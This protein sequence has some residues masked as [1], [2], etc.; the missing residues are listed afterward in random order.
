MEQ[1]IES[2]KLKMQEIEKLRVASF[3]RLREMAEELGRVGI[4]REEKQKVHAAHDELSKDPLFAEWERLAW[5]TMKL[6]RQKFDIK[7]DLGITKAAV[8]SSSA[9]PSEASEAASEEAL[10]LPPRLWG[11]MTAK[12]KFFFFTL[13][14][15]STFWQ[16]SSIR[17]IM[18]VFLPALQLTHQ[19]QPP[20]KSLKRNFK[21]WRTISLGKKM[22]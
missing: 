1:Q 20:R 9:Q 22:K 7:K 19:S 14:I 4:T 8:T 5:H 15:F 13:L 11:R 10:K 3:R 16:I 6:Q 18:H 2:A 17:T 21:N 12:S